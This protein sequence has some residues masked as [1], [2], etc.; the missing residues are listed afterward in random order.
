[1]KFPVD[2]LAWHVCAETGESAL[3]R[4]VVVMAIPNRNQ[5]GEEPEFWAWR[6]RLNK[7]R[8]YGVEH[9]REQAKFSYHE[10]R[11]ESCG[12]SV[13][14]KIKCAS[15]GYLNSVAGR[16]TEKGADV[17]LAALALNGAWKQ[18]YSTL[19]ILSK[20]SDFGPLVR[21]LKEVHAGQGRTYNFFSAYPTCGN[22]A[23]SHFGVPGMKQLQ[24][25]QATYASLIAQP[26]AAVRPPAPAASQ[27]SP[28]TRS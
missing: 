14:R 19:V 12:E 28:D 22:P 6:K 4:A 13:E 16:R 7:L 18:E 11:C 25:D 21:Q 9:E 17:S 2:R 8:N 1:M 5:P 27:G 3:T 10:T 20:D 26:F 15:C 23:H 24:I